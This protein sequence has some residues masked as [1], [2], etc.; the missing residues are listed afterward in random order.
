MKKISN[1]A[2]QSSLNNIFSYIEITSG[3][4]KNQ[5][6]YS[7]Y[8]YESLKKHLDNHTADDTNR[9]SLFIQEVG[10][11]LAG[12]YVNGV[13]EPQSTYDNGGNYSANMI[14]TCPSLTLTIND[15]SFFS[16]DDLGIEVGNTS[17]TFTDPTG[18]PLQARV[19]LYG[20]CGA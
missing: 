8:A 5:K 14:I 11:G 2:L 4:I 18:A 20:L 3:Y 15:L 16:D 19:C 1:I 7:H 13:E 17:I 6:S 12:F 9:F 10:S